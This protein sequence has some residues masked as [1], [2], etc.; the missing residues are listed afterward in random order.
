MALALYTPPFTPCGTRLGAYS[1]LV[2]S[3]DSQVALRLVILQCAVI[4][5]RPVDQLGATLFCGGVWEEFEDSCVRR[6]G[7]DC[8]SM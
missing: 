4:A 3:K 6:W 5:S 2:Q 7:T 1:S 8:V